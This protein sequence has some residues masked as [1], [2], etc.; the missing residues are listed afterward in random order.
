MLCSATEEKVLPWNSVGGKSS[1]E[2]R[3]AGNKAVVSAYLELLHCGS[4]TH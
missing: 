2:E 1:S 3:K 4:L